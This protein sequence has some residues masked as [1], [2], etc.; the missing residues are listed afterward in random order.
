MRRGLPQCLPAACALRT[1]PTT[2][3]TIISLS[4]SLNADI[5][6]IMEPAHQ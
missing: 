2:R 1:P 3:S 6:E 4:I 5:V